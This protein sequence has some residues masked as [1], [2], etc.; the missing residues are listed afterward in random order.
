MVRSQALAPALYNAAWA[1]GLPAVFARFWWRG[2]AEPAYR[3]GWAQ[4]LGRWPGLGAPSP[5]QPRVWLHAV[6]LGETRAAQPL[7]RELRQALPGMQL[8]LTTGTATGL[9]AGAELLQPGDLHGWVPLDTPGATRR[10]LAHTR[11]S[12][13]VL[14]ETETWPNLLHQARRAGVPMVLANARLSER[15]L[16]KGLSWSALTRPMM[17]S[18][19][20]VCAQ[21]QDDAQRLVR[22]G[23]R[24]ACV[25]VAGNLKFDLQPP[26]VLL[27]QGRRWSGRTVME[28]AA[29]ATAP[30]RRIVMAASWREGEDPALLR[31]WTAQA[32]TSLQRPLL[33]VVP[34]HPQ[35]FD[36]VHAALRSAGLVVSRRSRWSPDGPGPADWQADVWLGDSVGEMPA[37]YAA[38]DVALLGGSF[39]PLG[40][41][42]LIEAAACGCPLVMGPHTFNF[43][44]A[45]QR[46]LEEGAALRAADVA[47]AVSL[48]L[49]IDEERLRQQRTAGLAFSAHH[50]GAAQRQAHVVAAL[51]ASA[52]ERPQPPSSGA[53]A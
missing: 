45:A 53:R 49:T 41:Q 4:R 22:S 23:A 25:T 9:G 16:L 52:L 51:V 8:L 48:A 5:E 17:E 44:E 39:A 2:R 14:M 24:A 38:A 29:G 20:A 36:E 21:T 35:R 11:P 46:A 19:S 31:A 13:G 34:R 12:V 50:A 47:Q 37:Y 32:G 18:L 33:L 27:D 42:N 15:S 43:Q 28:A 26:E 3:Q 6:S 40:G 7:V 1:L 30:R 10:F